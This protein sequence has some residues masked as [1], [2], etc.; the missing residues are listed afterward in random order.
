MDLRPT[1]A[2]VGDQER[3]EAPATRTYTVRGFYSLSR[4]SFTL[5]VEARSAS[6]ALWKARE[7][8]GDQPEPST[9]AT[10]PGF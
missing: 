5:E 1:N 2:A 6:E 8:R 10:S 3:I 9:W 7:L 4:I